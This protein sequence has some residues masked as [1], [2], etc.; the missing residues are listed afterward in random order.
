[1][2][3]VR[4]GLEPSRGNRAS[5]GTAKCRKNRNNGDGEGHSRSR[6]GKIPEHALWR[7]ERRARSRDRLRGGAEA[8]SERGACT[9][10]RPRRGRAGRGG[11]CGLYL[12][13]REWRG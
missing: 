3:E 12:F 13:V 5:G 11:V 9:L 7:S 4:R 8:D 1:M 10:R 6:F 2:A